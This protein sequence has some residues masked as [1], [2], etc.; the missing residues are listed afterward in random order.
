[1]KKNP[2]TGISEY[3]AFKR[4]HCTNLTAQLLVFA[5]LTIVISDTFVGR[6]PNVK[7]ELYQLPAKKKKKRQKQHSAL[8]AFVPRRPRGAPSRGCYL[9]HEA[10]SDVH[11]RAVRSS[12][13]PRI[14]VCPLYF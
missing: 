9:C 11:V 4:K 14:D 13:G 3:D 12:G 8:V 10:A 1:M 2:R 7:T 6:S 5:Y